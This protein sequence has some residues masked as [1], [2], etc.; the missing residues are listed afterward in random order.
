MNIT[1]KRGAIRARWAKTPADIEAAQRLRHACFMGGGA[2][3]A[4]AFDASARHLLVEARGSGELLCCCRMTVYD[5]PTGVRSSYAAQFYDLTAL[6][7]SGP[8]PMAEL[9]RFCVRPDAPSPDI[10]RVAWGALTAEVDRAGVALLF[11][12]SSFEGTDPAPYARV[13]SGLAARHLGPADLRPGEGRAPL[14]RFADVAGQSQPQCPA[15]PL[16]RTYL[17]MGGWVSDHAVIDHALGTLH[18]FTG[19]DIA[20]VPPARAAALRQIASEACN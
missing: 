12:C 2:L 1:M 8:A 5:A 7:R 3:D 14:A 10:L 13:F 19:L 11:G 18:V 6:A 9:G 20:A 15:P 4:D 16:L 17:A